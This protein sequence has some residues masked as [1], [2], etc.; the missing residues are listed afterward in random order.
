MSADTKTVV[1]LFLSVAREFGSVWTKKTRNTHAIRRFTRFFH[2]KRGPEN[3]A[4]SEVEIQHGG[5]IWTE[6]TKK[7]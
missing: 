7:K 4:A 6:R 3:N 1:S 5:S 2:A